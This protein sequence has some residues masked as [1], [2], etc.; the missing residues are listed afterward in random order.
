MRS[1]PRSAGVGWGGL[2]GKA[3]ELL[4]A[5]PRSGQDRSVLD[6]VCESEQAETSGIERLAGCW[7][8]SDTRVGSRR[9]P[10]D[11]DLPQCSDPISKSVR[12]LLS[13]DPVP[14]SGPIADASA[15]FPTSAAR[16]AVYYTNIKEQ[17]PYRAHREADGQWKVE[18]LSID[19]GG[20]TFVAP[21][22][23]FVLVDGRADDSHGKGDIYVA[24][25]TSERRWSRPVNLGDKVNSEFSETCPSLSADGKYLFFSRYDEPDE[26]AQIYWVDS[27]VIDAARK[28]QL[29]IGLLIPSGTY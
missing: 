1:L 14:L 21:D 5:A 8:P 18:P 9:S 3:R 7:C 24:F 27:A 26:V 23:S 2:R 4:F 12:N 25:A 28:R 20:H 15:F 22:E 16:G 17:K 19:F 10:C 11:S 13:V 29:R 6:T